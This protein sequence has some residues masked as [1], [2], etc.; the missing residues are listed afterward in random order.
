MTREYD[1][2]LFVLK[3]AVITQDPRSTFTAQ[4]VCNTRGMLEAQADSLVAEY[5]RQVDFER[6]PMRSA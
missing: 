2:E 3:N 6:W 4:R 5:L 1:L